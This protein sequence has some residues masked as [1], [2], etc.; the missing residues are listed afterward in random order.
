MKTVVGAGLGIV[1]VVAALLA[2]SGRP[3]P[4]ALDQRALLWVT[5]VAGIAACS[6]GGIGAVLERANGD[7][8]N[9]VVL[10]GIVLGL[11][12]GLAIVGVA[13]G[14]R[15][16]PLQTATQWLVVLGSVVMIKVVLATAQAVLLRPGV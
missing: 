8:S 12:A 14:L 2:A 5:A 15:V 6:V 13:A 7:W 9:P 16:G 3:V 4:G 1:A 11:C 10:A